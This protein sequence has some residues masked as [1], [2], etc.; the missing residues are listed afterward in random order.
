MSSD[1]HTR[2]A[3]KEDALEFK[4]AIATGAVKESAISSRT[5]I[6]MFGLIAFQ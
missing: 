2:P 6:Q 4:K 1:S 5:S 3:T